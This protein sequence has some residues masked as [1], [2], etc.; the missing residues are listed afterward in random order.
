MSLD[1]LPINIFDI[2]VLVVL[3]AGFLA[4]RRHGMS[5]ELLGL[6][7]WLAV[8]LVC[9]LLYGPLGRM[10]NAATPFSLLASYLIVYTVAAGLILGFFALFKHSIGGKLIG[11]DVF[12]RSEYYLGM[13]SGVVRYTCVLIFVL[14][15]LNSRFFTPQEVSAMENFQNDVYGSNFFPTWHTAQEVVFEKSI[16]GR[17]IKDG[18]GFLLIEPTHLDDKALHQKEFSGP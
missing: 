11:S 12:G 16:C 1:Q 6:L 10:L 2:I 17:I 15:L 8:V 13:A 18:L 5:E 3:A 7:K 9:G 14:A 4:G